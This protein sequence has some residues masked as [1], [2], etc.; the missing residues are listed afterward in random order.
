MMMLGGRTSY[1]FDE[2]K[3][4]AIE[5]VI[6]MRGSVLGLTLLVEELVIEHQPPHRKVRETRGRSNLLVIGACRMGFEISGSSGPSRL[7][8]VIDYDHPATFAENLLCPL[9]RTGNRQLNI[10]R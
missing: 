5:S 9:F 7:C 3:G 4:R 6:R 10:T 1:A 8:V 2:T